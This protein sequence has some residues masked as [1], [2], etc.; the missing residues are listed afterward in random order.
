[1]AAAVAVAAVPALAPRLA[2]KD[3]R[4]V[5]S[6][7]V[8]LAAEPAAGPNLVSD[9]FGAYPA[10]GA[11]GSPG[12]SGRVQQL[13]TKA[14]ADDSDPGSLAAGLAPDQQQVI[15]DF[16]H[17][18]LAEVLRVQATS[19]LQAPYQVQIINDFFEGGVFQSE[20]HRFL[21][22][23]TDPQ[24]Q[25]FINDFVT[26]GVIQIVRN[27]LLDATSDPAARA[28][29]TDFFPD[30]V[31]DYR[32]GPITVLQRRLIAAAKGNTVVINLVNA[33]FDNPIVLAVRHLIG[34]GPLIGTPLNEL[35]EVVSVH[36]FAASVERPVSKSPEPSAAEQPASAPSS[37]SRV[38]PKPAA[39]TADSTTPAAEPGPV[40]T[41]L[42]DSRAEPATSSAVS[43]PKPTATAR[44]D[45][46]DAKDADVVKTGNKVE[47]TTVK[48]VEHPKS[49][50]GSRGLFGQVADAIS[51]S[52]AGG[53]PATAADAGNDGTVGDAA[54]G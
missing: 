36:S 24:Q 11:A 19:R 49:G 30:E 29:I 10:G 38:A 51:K 54:A 47:P 1:M 15:D 43:K 33:V 6:T 50:E 40:T 27:R 25:E 20:A 18:G 53:N 44:A 2:P 4:V 31:T 22:L 32:G 35:P 13:P 34:G 21:Q 8:A 39:A 45:T 28:A 37:A 23:F 46:D 26:G 5:Q 14:T 16:R 42:T 7:Q 52:V 12:V 41:E 17:G 48:D 9:Y 3:I